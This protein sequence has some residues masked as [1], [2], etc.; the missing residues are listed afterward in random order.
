V[1]LLKLLVPRRRLL[2]VKQLQHLQVVMQCQ[3][4]QNLRQQ[5]P[6]QSHQCPLMSRS[7]MQASQ[8][9]SSR[10]KQKALWLHLLKCC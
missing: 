6:P 7:S 8:Q 5:L 10:M 4:N 3:Q 1:A 9:S 2:Q